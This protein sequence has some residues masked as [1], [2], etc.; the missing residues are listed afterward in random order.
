MKTL[1]YI[2]LIIFMSTF[3]GCGDDL[4]DDRSIQVIKNIEADMGLENSGTDLYTRL[5]RIRFEIHNSD[6]FSSSLVVFKSADSIF[7]GETLE[8]Q[9]VPVKTYAHEKSSKAVVN[10]SDSTWN[11]QRTGINKATY[12]LET[13]YY[14]KG[15]NQIQ[16]LVPVG[17]DTLPFSIEFYVK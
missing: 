17:K 13:K 4:L 1:F 5:K 12:I 16:G 3:A 11:V 2:I 6:T 14:K 10:I 7:Y 15:A 9:L 8:V